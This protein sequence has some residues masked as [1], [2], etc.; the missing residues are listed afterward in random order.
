MK[1]HEQT[2]DHEKMQAAI[3]KNNAG[4]VCINF[5]DPAYV[6]SQCIYRGQNKSRIYALLDDHEFLIGEISDLMADAFEQNDKI[7]LTATL[8]DGALLEL[9]APF[10]Q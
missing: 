5:N 9:Y 10:F 1:N 8:P 7:L 2:Q 3:L 6:R 4:A